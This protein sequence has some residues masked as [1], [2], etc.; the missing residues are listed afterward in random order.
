M[1][2]STDSDGA[3]HRYFCDEPWTG[4]FAIQVNQDVTFCPCYL[5]ATIGNLA[6][7]SIEDIW[8][9]DL[10]VELR[11]QFEAGELPDMCADQLCPVVLREPG[12]SSRSPLHSE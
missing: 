1:S 8:N 11:R 7:A 5:K 10:L 3:G 12:A 4:V 2:R 6:E 9:A